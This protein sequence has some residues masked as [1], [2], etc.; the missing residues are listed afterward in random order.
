MSPLW[1]DLNSKRLKRPLTWRR[2][3]VGENVKGLSRD[4]AVGYRVQVGDEQWM[5]YRSID[6]VANRSVLGHNTFGSFV[7]GKID[8]KGN[9]KEILTMD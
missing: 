3:T 9:V 4:V 7:C 5:I 1:I 8:D 2:L 6:R